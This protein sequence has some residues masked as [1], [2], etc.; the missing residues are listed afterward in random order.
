MQAIFGTTDHLK[1]AAEIIRKGEVQLTTEHKNK[2]LAEKKRQIIALLHR[3]AINPQNN[4]PHPISR[5]EAAI[6]EAR[7]KVD[8][9]R[10]AEDQFKD[11]VKAINAIL[12]IKVETRTIEIAMPA[13]YAVKAFHALKS[14]GKILNEEWKNDG[15]LLASMELPAGMQEDLEN[16]LN[17]ISHGNV[18]IRIISA[19]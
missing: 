3:N 12:P 8:E 1:V 11:V 15:S 5:I 9:F 4:L 6:N 10:T 18:D 14:H 13:Q 7:I 17:K 19:R 2:L 16:E